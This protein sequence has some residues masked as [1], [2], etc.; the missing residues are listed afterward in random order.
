MPDAWD[1]FSIIGVLRPLGYVSPAPF[2]QKNSVS[3]RILSTT[4]PHQSHPKNPIF[5]PTTSN[6]PG[7]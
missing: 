7:K 1:S 4:S 6:S 3:G 5:T 2:S